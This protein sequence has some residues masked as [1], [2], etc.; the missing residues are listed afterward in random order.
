MPKITR[1]DAL[2]SMAVAGT[3]L[4]AAAAASGAQA[5]AAA[6]PGGTFKAVTY[7]AQTWKLDDLA[8][9]N[10]DLMEQHYKLYTGYVTN[11]NKANTELAQMMADGKADAFDFA[12]IRRRLGF[13]Y[14]GMRMHEYYFSQMKTGGSLPDLKLRGSIENVWGT[15]DNW[16]AD[17]VRTG[18]MRGIGWAV[19]YQDPLNPAGLSNHWIGDHELFQVVG[20]TPVFVMDVWEHAYVLQ[21]GA[22]G[23]KGYVDAFMKNIDWSVV[24]KRLK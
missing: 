19:L 13:E 16:A 3:G 6:A 23:R 14:N 11:T 15:W 7:A 20:F 21:F 18:M 24:G 9:L 1:R 10:K 12:E 4:V 22:T 17:F 8:G 2:T 5:P